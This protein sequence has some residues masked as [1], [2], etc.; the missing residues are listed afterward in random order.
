MSTWGETPCKKHELLRD[1]KDKYYIMTFCANDF[2][3]SFEIYMY[4]LELRSG[5]NLLRQASHNII[6]QC[7]FIPVGLE[8]ITMGCPNLVQVDSDQVYICTRSGLA[9]VIFS[10]PT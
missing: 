9:M 7:M 2:M 5:M 10:R 6:K 3:F 4:Y 8:N 1:F